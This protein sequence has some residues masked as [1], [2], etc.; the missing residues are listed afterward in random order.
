VKSRVLHTHS[1]DLIVRYDKLTIEI[2]IRE[3]RHSRMGAC[4]LT[5]VS[6]SWDAPAPIMTDETLT[7]GTLLCRV[8]GR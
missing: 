7:I 2:A 8:C 1:G 4:M 3:W 6:A 5:S